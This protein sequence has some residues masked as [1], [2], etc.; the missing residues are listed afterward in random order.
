MLQTARRTQIGIWNSTAMLEKWKTSFQRLRLKEWSNLSKQVR[1][2]FTVLPNALIPGHIYYWTTF[3]YDF[4]EVINNSLTGVKRNR[5]VAS[6]GFAAWPFLLLHRSFHLVEPYVFQVEYLTTRSLGPPMQGPL[7]CRARASQARPRR[8]SLVARTAPGGG[9]LIWQPCHGLPIWVNPES[10]LARQ[11]QRQSQL[12]LQVQVPK[13][14]HW[15]GLQVLYEGLP[16]WK[17]TTVVK[18]RQT[19]W[20][21]HEPQS[22][23][24]F[25]PVDSIWDFAPEDIMGYNR[26]WR[27]SK[28]IIDYM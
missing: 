1:S 28:D 19:A 27:I 22:A 23:F 4:L 7:R 5:A 16:T 25:Q 17:A 3:S 10:V 21:S 9:C 12:R 11:R 26:I 6:F 8:L 2:L 18:V 15:P 14:N 24:Y 20:L 13:I